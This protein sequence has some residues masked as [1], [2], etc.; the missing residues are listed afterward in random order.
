MDPLYDRDPKSTVD[1]ASCST[2]E[3]SLPSQDNCPNIVQMCRIV[4]CVLGHPM[5]LIPLNEYRQ[6]QILASNLGFAIFVFSFSVL[7]YLSLAP[8]SR[9]DLN[10]FATHRF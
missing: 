9:S 7:L 6:F 10:K 5:A 4:A 3:H 1:A 8:F 2:D